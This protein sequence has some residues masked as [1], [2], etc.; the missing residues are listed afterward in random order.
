MF[1]GNKGILFR[2]QKNV[3]WIQKITNLSF[4]CSFWDQKNCKYDFKVNNASPLVFSRKLMKND[5]SFWA[6]PIQR[7]QLSNTKLVFL[8]GLKS[9][10]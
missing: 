9:F 10:V 4:L 5:A 1:E 6:K 7:V 8:C 3:F 2:Q